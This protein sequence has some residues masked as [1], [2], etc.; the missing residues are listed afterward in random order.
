MTS[1]W[2]RLGDPVGSLAHC[3][4]VQGY[5]RRTKW[6]IKND[7]IHALKMLQTRRIFL[8][9]YINRGEMCRR[10]SLLDL[11]LKVTL[12]LLNII[13]SLTI[14][15]VIPWCWLIE[16]LQGLKHIGLAIAI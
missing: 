16:T 5:N 12:E 14:I 3:T 9:F 8:E 4:R 15:V 1:R 7:H 2:L 6:V 13:C 10:G 11:T